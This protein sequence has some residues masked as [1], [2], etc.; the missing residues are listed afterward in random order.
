[1]LHRKHW[2]YLLQMS[3]PTPRVSNMMRAATET[4]TMIT[5]GLCSLEASA[6]KE[7]HV[8]KDKQKVQLVFMRAQAIITALKATEHDKRIDFLSFS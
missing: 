2:P 3:S 1:M 4:T 8:S 6:T 7:K 5:T